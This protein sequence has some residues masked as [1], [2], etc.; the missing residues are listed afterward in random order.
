MDIEVLGGAREIGRSAILV[1][2]ALLLD[3]GVLTGNP[4]RFPVGDPD[5]EAVVVSHGHL[6]HVGAVPSLLSGTTARP[7]ADVVLYES[8]YADADHAAT[9][10]GRGSPRASGRP[11]G[12]EGRSSSPRSPSAAPRR[13]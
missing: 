6:G 10:S 12:R 4:P 9:R 1:N 11:S 2:D 5:P 8:T 3:Y 7:D 13:Y